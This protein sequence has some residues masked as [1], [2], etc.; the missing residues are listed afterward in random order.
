MSLIS[1]MSN[2]LDVATIRRMERTLKESAPACANHQVEFIGLSG[3]GYLCLH[4]KTCKTYVEIH[5][6]TALDLITGE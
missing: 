4:C 2:V 3:S 6:A 1:D 5:P